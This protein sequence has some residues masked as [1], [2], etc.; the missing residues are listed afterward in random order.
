MNPCYRSQLKGP[1]YSLPSAHNTWSLIG[2]DILNS[3]TGNYFQGL[4]IRSG[5]F[6]LWRSEGIITQIHLKYACSLSLLGRIVSY[7]GSYLLDH[8]ITLFGLSS[9]SW[10][11]HQIHISVPPNSLLDSGI[12]PIVILTFGQMSNIALGPHIFSFIL[13]V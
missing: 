4:Y 13:D 9:I 6:Q 8:S 10:S 11:G 1:N 12:D 7:L 2:Q 3:D 5:I